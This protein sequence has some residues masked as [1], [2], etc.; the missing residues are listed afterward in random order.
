MEQ[1]LAAANAEHRHVAGQRQRRTMRQLERRAASLVMTVGWL[2]A[3]PN[4]AGIDVE[5]AAGDD[6]A[7]D[8]RDIVVDHSA[9]VRQQ[10][11]QPAR[12]AT[13]RQ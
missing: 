7:V 9:L 13:A 6:Q 2:A 1:L 8:Q 11:R 5:R 10:Q 12:A 4:R 3:A